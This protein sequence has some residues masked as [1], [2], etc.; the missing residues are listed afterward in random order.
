M[1]GDFRTR[2]T[3]A[4]GGSIGLVLIAMSVMSFLFIRQTAEMK[5]RDDLHAAAD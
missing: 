2:L 3:L 4:F 5:V 1:R